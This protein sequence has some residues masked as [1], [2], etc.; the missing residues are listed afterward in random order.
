MSVHDAIARA[1]AEVGIIPPKRWKH[2]RWSATDTQDGKRGKGDGRVIVNDA[3]VTAYNWQV[4]A[5][6]TVRIGEDG[7]VDRRRL[8]L[9]L[10]EQRRKARERAERAALTA[11][12]ILDAAV[13]AKH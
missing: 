5:A 10:G 2:G 12:A 1:C 3:Y 4:G 6:A 11:R 9:A 7:P 13:P 8:A